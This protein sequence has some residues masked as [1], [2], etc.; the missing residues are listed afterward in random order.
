MTLLTVGFSTSIPKIHCYTS[1]NFDCLILDRE[2]NLAATLILEN[3]AVPLNHTDTPTPLSRYSS[4]DSVLRLD[5]SSNI[6]GSVAEKAMMFELTANLQA[7]P[8]K[9]N[10]NNNSPIPSPKQKISPRK[11]R[12]AANTEKQTENNENIKNT[13]N[14]ADHK[15]VPSSVQDLLDDMAKQ[16]WSDLV[17]AESDFT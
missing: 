8:K 1:N 10:G 9:I 3:F 12:F 16:S 2:V 15:A 5:G 11:R 6:V 17:E 4:S 7:S 13:A 14:V